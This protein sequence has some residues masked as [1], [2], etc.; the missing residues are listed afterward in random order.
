MKNDFTMFSGNTRV[1]S[2]K[3]EDSD[4]S[5]FQLTGAEIIFAIAKSKSTPILSKLEV[6]AG[7]EIVNEHKGHFE[8]TIDPTVT[9]ALEGVFYYEVRVK[10]AAGDVSLALYG[11]IT[12]TATLTAPADF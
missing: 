7:I 6:G 9:E 10:R 12:I 5:I 1:L 2:V 8:V 4:G 11:S 3:L